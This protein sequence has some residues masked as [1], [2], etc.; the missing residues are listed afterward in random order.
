M[1]LVVADRVQETTST[2]STS[3]YVLL[4]A[5]TGYQSFG[6]VLANGD[7]TYYAITNDT[8]WEVGIGTYSTTGPTLARTTI[9]ASSNGGSAVSWGVGVK[10]IFISY[11]ASKASFLDANGDLLVADKIVHTGDTNTAIRF[12]TADTV[13]VETGG[14]ERFKVENS[15]ITTTVPVLLPADPTLPLQ[16]ATKEYVDTIASAGIHYHDPVRVESPINLNAT[17][18]NGTSGVGATL[19]NAGTQAALV[20]DGVTVATNDRVLI[21]QQT[22]QTQNGVYT[23]T[24][25]GSGST[26][27]VLTRSTDTDSY[28]PSDPDA[29]GA[30]DAF[31]VQ[32]G[33]TGAGELYVCNTEGTITFGTT[34]ITFTQIASTAVYTAGSGLALTGTVFSNTAQDQVVTLTQGGATTITG[35][36]PN[37]TITSTDTTY[38]AGGGIGL[39]GTTFS[40]AA[41]SGLT[42]D[43]DGL[44]H[45]DTSS[46]ASVDNTGATFVQDINLDGF[47]HVT[48]AASVTVTPSLIGAPST[49]GVG[50]SGSW[51][52]SVTGTAA[53]VTGTVAVGNGGTGATTDSQART[54]L[55]LAIG[56]NVQAYDAG[57]QSISGLTTSANQMIYTTA[58]DTYATTSLT[59]AGRAILD[60]ADAAAQ[61][62]TLGL[63]TM[64]TQASSSVTIT[65]GTI[66][67]ITDLAIADGGTG[68]S[69]AGTART[70]LGLA[71]G[72][73]VQAWDANLDQIAALAPTAD[74]FIVGNG[75][76]WTL[77]TPASALASLGVTATAAELNTLDGITATVTELNYTDGVTSAIQTQL[78]TKAPLASPALTGTPIA[79]TATV[80]TNTTQVATTAFV[81]A[82]I[83]NDAPS[84]TGTGASG[85]WGISISGNAA[86]VSS[87]TSGQVTTALGYTPV[88]KAGDSSI[89][90]LQ[91]TQG[92]GVRFGHTNQTDGNDG[93]IAAGR[94]ASGLNIVGTQTTAGTGR[95]VRVWGSLISD[96]GVSYV[97]NSG[98]W[99]IS[100]T[101]N[102]A[103][104]T[105]ASNTTS[106]SSAVG[107]GYTWTGVQYFQSNANTAASSGSAPLQAYSSS[108]GAIMSFHRA[109][110]YAVNMGLDSD[111]VF[112]IGGWSAGANLLQMDMS[113]NL[114]MLGSVSATSFSSAGV[115]AGTA[116]LAAGAVGSYAFCLLALDTDTDYAAGNTF[117]GSDL[118]YAGTSSATSGSSTVMATSGTPSGT[119]R[120]MGYLQNVSSGGGAGARRNGSTVFLRIS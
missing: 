24:N 116:G 34:N 21:Y 83:A 101:G 65:G 31:F 46:Q 14:T 86:T 106:I 47:G 13:S 49:T 74:N 88:N 17:Y 75:T 111:N 42:Q 72:T 93:Y 94:F 80:G 91:F 110:Q 112:R 68:A 45:A 105:T 117:A 53:N 84:K 11:A 52:I 82:E 57:L 6:A 16:A 5:A 27:W 12:P 73:N 29:L 51:G 81:N 98:T 78:D 35:T 85:T 62:T 103:T 70:N 4:G 59:A 76:A 115:G 71:I 114:T 22:T 119:W 92:D 44:S 33:A 19:T 32:Q 15:T 28:G 40:V 95:Q 39:A 87:I 20:I 104:A 38:T 67:G 56:S 61:R 118:R 100:I 77:E 8:D 26:N 1:A 109:G 43:A 97:Q 48:G 9:L 2:T 7:T 120:N 37:F 58:L 60:D 99:G 18:N 3:S 89:G 23:V 96:S 25:T 54:N 66:S 10:N 90:T 55:G 64:A 69:D 108:G 63:G 36:Y 102:A 79:P 107:T 113:G 50:A 41:G 30:G